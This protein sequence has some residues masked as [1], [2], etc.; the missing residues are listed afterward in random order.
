MAELVV[1]LD[2][3]DSTAALDMATRLRGAVN[4]VKVGLELYT[5][6][7]PSIVGALTDMGFRVFLDLK[8]MDIPNTVRGAVR[9]AVGVGAD[10]VNVHACGGRRMLEAAREGL[11]DGAARTGRS[12]ILLA[13]TVLTSMDA[14][15][16]ALPEGTSVAD[17]ALAYARTV[18]D[19][20][21]DGVVCS[22]HEAQAIKAACGADFACLTP[23][24]RMADAGDDQRRVMTP[25]MAVRAGSDYLVAGRP[26]TRAASP[27]DAAALFLEQMG[28]VV[29]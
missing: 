18:R 26:I 29:L 3:P 7:G 19:C 5:A 13:V 20:E 4:W 10:M 15:D 14:T 28:R 2:F 9:S 12:P 23:G 17:L 24:I 11:E 6:T 1:A 25:E 16:L 22:G 8:F 21:L 27:A